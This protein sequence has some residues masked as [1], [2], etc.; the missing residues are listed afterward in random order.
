MF[1]YVS[2]EKTG[3]LKNS[4]KTFYHKERFNFR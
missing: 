4:P 3:Y 1:A 2:W